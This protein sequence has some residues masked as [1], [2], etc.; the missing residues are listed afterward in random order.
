MKDDKFDL[1][2]KVKKS[3]FADLARFQFILFKLAIRKLF[4]G[5]ADLNK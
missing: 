5:T 2:K 4:I 1:E 3:A